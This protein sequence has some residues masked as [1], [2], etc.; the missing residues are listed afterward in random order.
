MTATG[1]SVRESVYAGSFWMELFPLH[2]FGLKDHYV[3]VRKARAQGPALHSHFSLHVA[4]STRTVPTRPC[5]RGSPTSYACQGPC[6]TR[7]SWGAWRGHTLVR[8]CAW[9]R[10]SSHPAS[11]YWRG[12]VCATAKLAAVLWLRWALSLAIQACN[13]TRANIGPAYRPEL[14]YTQDRPGASYFYFDRCAFQLP[15]S[16]R[17]FGFH[18]RSSARLWVEIASFLHVPTVLVRLLTDLGAEGAPC[19]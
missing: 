12:W 4:V 7:C 18:N 8:L 6:A 10:R 19:L 5:S 2:F 17:P 1:G 9:R 16:H 15:A 13:N 14:R 11:L 3:D